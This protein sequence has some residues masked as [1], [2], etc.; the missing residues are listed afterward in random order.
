MGRLPKRGGRGD[1]LDGFYLFMRF[2]PLANNTQPLQYRQLIVSYFIRY[3]TFCVKFVSCD[4]DAVFVHHTLR[5]I[6]WE[7]EDLNGFLNSSQFRVII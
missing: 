3:F 5:N 4:I 2:S 6:S 1:L 7:V